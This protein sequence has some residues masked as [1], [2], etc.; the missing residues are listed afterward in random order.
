KSS[1]GTAANFNDLAPPVNDVYDFSH[2]P[3][4][5]TCTVDGGS[6]PAPTAI[7][8]SGNN[9]FPNG[10][11][12]SAAQTLGYTAAMQ[13]AGI[14][15]TFAYIAD[16]HDK[17]DS[18]GGWSGGAGGLGP[19]SACYEQQLH[20]YNQAFQAYFERLAADGIN[21]SNTLFVFTVEE[22]DH[23]SG[24]PPT[25]AS[26]C[27]GVTV[28]CTYT[29]GSSGPN[30]VGEIQ[31]NL[32]DLVKSET[33][34]TDALGSHLDSAT[35][36]YV[37]NDPNGPPGPTNPK[38]RGLEQAASGLTLHNPRTNTEVPAVQHIA[39]QTTQDILHMTN[40]DPLRT[41]SFTMFGNADFFFTGQQACS[42]PPPAGATPGCPGVST[43]FAW[44]H[45]D[46]NPEVAKT[47]LGLVGP[48]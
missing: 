41:P 3:G 7:Q 47:W 12:P 45:G 33:G 26:T 17:H 14:P 10:F 4:P 35:D 23:F 11:N 28:A 13:E 34:N 18:G 32:Q 46:D 19:G 16:A 8:N 6:C 2:T 20:E 5:A 22:G 31:T 36:F 39:D 25:N 24:G 43:A 42:T 48:S 21:K 15:V 1:F 37:H 40:T 27:N 44:N 29:A 38:V 9:G 30:T